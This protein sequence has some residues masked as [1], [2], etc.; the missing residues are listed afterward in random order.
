MNAT[1]HEE[2]MPVCYGTNLVEFNFQSMFMLY[3]DGEEICGASTLDS[4]KAMAIA[5]GFEGEIQIDPV[6]SFTGFEEYPAET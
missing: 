3:I 6:A 5:M 4:C 1:I 2:V